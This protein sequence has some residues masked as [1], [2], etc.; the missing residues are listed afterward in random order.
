MLGRDNSIV[1]DL[2]SGQLLSK[3]KCTHCGYESLAFDNFWD[4]SLSFTRGLSL[5]NKC[6]LTRM[7][8][9]FLKEELIEDLLHCQKCKQK[10]KFKKNFV[11]WR[12]PKVLVIHLKRFHYGK[13]K[14]EKI[15]QSVR[16]PIKNLDLSEFVQESRN[17]FSNPTFNLFYR[18]S[19]C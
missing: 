3:T 11:I 9:H 12:L 5:L 2:F 6:D 10:R 16:F 1:T 14:K 8:E 7:I 4:L 13:Y 19:F 18:R 15:T 17:C